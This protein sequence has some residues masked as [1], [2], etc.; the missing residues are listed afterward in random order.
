M[1]R[2]RPNCVPINPGRRHWS[3]FVELCT[4]PGVK[5]GLV[6]DA[7]LAAL[8]V[9]HGCE[10]ASTDADFARFPKLKWRNPLA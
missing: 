10:L 3:L 9:E 7:Y 6:A 1:I 4:L 2:S 8:A 5:A